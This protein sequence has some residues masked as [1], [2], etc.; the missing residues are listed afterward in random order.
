VAVLRFLRELFDTEC[1]KR[2]HGVNL[3]LETGGDEMKSIPFLSACVAFAVLA[4]AVSPVAAAIDPIAEIKGISFDRKVFQDSG[5][6]KPLVFKDAEAAGKYLSKDNLAALTKKVDFKEQVVLVFAWRGS[7]QDK[8]TYAVLESYP[9]Q[10]VFSFRPGRTKD[11]RPHVKVF[12]LRSNVKW[13]AGRGGR[14]GRG[15]AKPSADYIKVEIQGTL[16]TGILAIGGE[17]TGM[18]I[19]ANNVT[20]ELDLG[21]NAALRKQAEGLNG[22]KVVVTGTYTL[23]QGVEIRQRS[24]VQ[25]TSLK[26]A[27]AKDREQSYVDPQGRLRS[28]LVLRDAQS[29]F[30]G[31]TGNVWTIEPD[32]TWRHQTFL[33]RMVRDP[34]SQG[35]LTRKQ[36][37][38]LASALKQHD[39]SGLPEKLGKNPGVNPHVFSISF[40]K[41]SSSMMLRGGADVPKADPR[42]SKTADQR[43]A[44]IVRAIRGTLQAKKEKP[45]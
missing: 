43:F 41:L 15:T 44:A 13:R 25:V 30:A 21:K 45:E 10:V 33:N 34:D 6:N 23:K 35:K 9:E 8:L 32:G 37:D 24:I 36:L 28:A 2:S 17:T 3:A 20:W 18:T 16:K 27:G 38:G 7:G 19:T 39:L 40:G 22:K 31:Q 26:A 4:G 29:G 5:R 1:V 12:A 11:L 42:Q 14:P